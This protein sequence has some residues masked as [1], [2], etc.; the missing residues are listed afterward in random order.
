MSSEVQTIAERW[1]QAWLEKDAATVDALMADDY[2]Y[3]SPSGHM[4]DRAAVLAV[5]R[6]PSYRLDHATRTE[7][8]IRPVGQN[9]TIVRH[10][11]QGSGSYE[12]NSFTDDNRAVMVWENQHNHWHLVL[13]QCSFSEDRGVDTP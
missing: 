2:L 13:D 5:I 6:S 1:Y 9:A 12:G 10:R 11:F 4:L 8:V 7:I 3:I